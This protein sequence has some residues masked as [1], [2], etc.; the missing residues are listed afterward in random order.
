MTTDLQSI[1]RVGR[2]SPLPAKTK[3]FHWNILRHAEEPVEVTLATNFTVSGASPGILILRLMA[4][5]H[6]LRNLIIRP[7][8]KYAMEVEFEID[9]LEDLVDINERSI[10]IPPEILSLTLGV[11]IGA[12]RG[13]LALECRNSSLI[14]YPLPI[15]NIGEIIARL[16]PGTDVSVSL[17][18]A[19][20][21]P[22]FG[23]LPTMTVSCEDDRK[24][25][26]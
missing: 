2:I 10:I 19:A 7:L 4:C 23:Q 16:T 12:L 26:G 21:E 18:K 24:E 13:M 9:N 17:E 22:G 15:M 8:L 3:F 6:S 5:Y 20:S 25:V 11:G 1:V 14:H